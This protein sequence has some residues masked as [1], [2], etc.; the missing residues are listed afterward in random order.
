V[1]YIT[2]IKKGIERNDLLQDSIFD[3]LLPQEAF[4]ASA[5]HW[6][7][8]TVVYE[9]LKLLHPS[10][11][12]RLLDVGSGCGKFCIA[13]ALLGP[14]HYT[15]VELRPWLHELSLEV[16]KDLGVERAEFILGDMKNL[17]WAQY[18]CFYFYNPFHEQILDEN[19]SDRKPIDRSLEF[20]VDNYLVYRRVVR[21][22]LEV[23]PSGTRV[24]TYH[25]M[26]GYFPNDYAL[27]DTKTVGSGE[28]K[29]WIKA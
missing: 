20:H 10:E 2:R 9:V 7:P 15:G 27:I 5:V 13:A 26:G 17:D 8:F 18:N 6:T 25:G 16:K 21:E 12:T 3:Y 19:T 29:L 28:V 14:G 23:C 11:N 22:K 1:H 4:D 24:V